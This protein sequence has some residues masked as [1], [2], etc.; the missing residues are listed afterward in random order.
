VLFAIGFGA[1]M[2]RLQ[3][4]ATKVTLGTSDGVAVAIVALG[5]VLNMAI[6]AA[7]QACAA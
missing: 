7:L 5:V 3:W 6:A 2:V 4:F 1:V